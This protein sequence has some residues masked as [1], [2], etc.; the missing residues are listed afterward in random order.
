[1]EQD[2]SDEDLMLEVRNGNHDAFEQLVDRHQQWAWSVAY[3]YLGDAS[4]AEDLVQDVF[5]K[6]FEARENYEPSAQFQTY[7]QRILVRT[8]IDRERKRKPLYTDEMP[9]G[10]KSSADP[11]DELVDEEVG[12]AI[13]ETLNDLPA[14]QRM[15][16][17][18]KY[19]QNLSYDE[20]AD[21]MNRTNKAVESL[22]SR[23]RGAFRDSAPEWVVETVVSTDSNDDT[24][25][26]SS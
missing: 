12:R 20:V 8:C 24:R 21:R 14:Q 5:L 15:V 3:S 19:I 11:L 26:V 13:Q 17:I 10:D 9:P 22:L 4:R 16:L 7:L 2:Q 6:I 18:L 23:A 25:E 1:M